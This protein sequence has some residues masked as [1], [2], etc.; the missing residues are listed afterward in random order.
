MKQKGILETKN[1]LVKSTYAC[2]VTS[3]HV[4]LCFQALSQNYEKQLL[5][6][7]SLSV[8]SSAWN[9]LFPTGRI[10]MKF[11]IVAFFVNLSRKFKFH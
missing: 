3:S 11:G 6:S 7:S 1:S 5:A 8:S 2:Y 10:F 4:T 9:S